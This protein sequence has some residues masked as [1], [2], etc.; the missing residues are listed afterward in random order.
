MLTPMDIGTKQNHEHSKVICMEEE[1][2]DGV[3]EGEKKDK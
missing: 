1:V 2:L 3:G